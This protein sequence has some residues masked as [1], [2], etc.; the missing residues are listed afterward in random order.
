MP[1]MPRLYLV[2]HA[3]P[4][5]TFSQAADGG[6]DRTG[7]EQAESVA[8]RLAPLGPMDIVI[9][10]LRRTRETA[11]PLERRWTR[12]GRIDPGVGEIPSPMSDPAAR[13]M[14]AQEDAAIIDS[15][16]AIGVPTLIILGDRDTAFVAPCEYM[17][18]KIPGARLEI[19]KDAGHSSNL[20]QPEAFNRVLLDF[21]G[22]LA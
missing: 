5:A 21:V 20:D 11:A 4:E 22:S 14:L 10:P 19:I 15:L 13:G 1:G 9:S 7:L 12:S 16:P 18:K 3:R 8:D 2:R 6:L 17:A